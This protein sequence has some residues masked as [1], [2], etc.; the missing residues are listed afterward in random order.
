LNDSVKFLGGI[1][2]QPPDDPHHMQT[3]GNRRLRLLTT[4]ATSALHLFHTVLR[5]PAL[6]CVHDHQDISLRPEELHLHPRGRVIARAWKV[7]TNFA[8]SLLMSEITYLTETL[9]T[10]EKQDRMQHQLNIA[11]G[12]RRQDLQVL[13]IIH[14]QL[15]LHQAARPPHQFQCQ[16]TTVQAAHL[17]SLHLRIPV[18]TSEETIEETLEEISE[19]DTEVAADH[20]EVATEVTSPVLR[21]DEA[22]QAGVGP[23][24]MVEAAVHH[25][26]HIHPAKS[27]LMMAVARQHHMDIEMVAWA[28][29]QA[30]TAAPT[31]RQP[32]IRVP[33]VSTSISKICQPSKKAGS[34][35]RH[36]TIPPRRISWRRRQRGCA[37]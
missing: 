30:D 25:A 24:P 4:L 3:L 13:D 16:R 23:L 19:V 11:T 21:R 27:N 15:C 20:Q 7:P 32:P 8:L 14:L 10:L 6:H 35:C 28:S 9:V 31:A 2:S 5:K 34:D 12:L 17:S 1:L 36:C 22:P 33:S 37:R 26:T 29:G 18:A